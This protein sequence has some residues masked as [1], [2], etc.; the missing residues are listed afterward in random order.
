VGFLQ[1]QASCFPLASTG[2]Y[3]SGCDPSGASECLVGV[4]FDTYGD[5]AGYDYKC[6]TTKRSVGGD[7]NPSENLGQT[8]E[9]ADCKAGL[10]CEATE[11]YPS[12]WAYHCRAPADEGDDCDTNWGDPEFVN[13]GEALTCKNAVCVPQLDAGDDCEDTDNPGYPDANICKNGA[14]V[15]NWDENGHAFI[16]TDAPVPESNGGSD[17]TCSG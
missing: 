11:S 17:L 15:E 2:G 8:G 7:C 1:P 6:G 5:F 4:L 14:C 3:S 10:L 16:C 13:C 12:P 9:P